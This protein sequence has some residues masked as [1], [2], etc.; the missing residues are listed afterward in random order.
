MLLDNLFILKLY[1]FPFFFKILH[2]LAQVRLEQ[3]D[4]GLEHL[5]LLVLLKLLDGNCLVLLQEVSQIAFQLPVLVC[6]LV[7]FVLQIFQFVLL[8]EG[9]V[10]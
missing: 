8:Q 3:V 9:L 6:K 2:N 1:Q 4:L 7:R 5:N 10:F